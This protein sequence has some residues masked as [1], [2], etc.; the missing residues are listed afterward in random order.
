MSTTVSEGKR[1]QEKRKSEAQLSMICFTQADPPPRAASARNSCK[2]LQPLI[3]L[4]FVNF[5][6][7]AKHIIYNHEEVII[8]K[9]DYWKEMTLLLH[10]HVVDK[11]WW[12]AKQS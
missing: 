5:S 9:C 4:F 2:S 7:V 3:R 12:I 10:E 1:I 11:E 6:L 8:I